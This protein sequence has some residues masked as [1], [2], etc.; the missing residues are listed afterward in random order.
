[1]SCAS[2]SASVRPSF[3]PSALATV[4][5]NLRDFN[6]VRQPVAEVIGELGR[7]NLRLILQ[8][9]KGARMNNAVAIALEDVAV[10]VLGLGV[11]SPK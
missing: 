6:R 3:R 11:T 9:A 10:R 7:K 8:P 1:M 2:A 4:R 5:G